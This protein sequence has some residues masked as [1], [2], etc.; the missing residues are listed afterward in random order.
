MFVNSGKENTY[1]YLPKHLKPLY[2]S[3]VIPIEK[4]MQSQMSKFVERK[5][6]FMNG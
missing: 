6:K 1:K 2:I 4:C 5:N 3:L